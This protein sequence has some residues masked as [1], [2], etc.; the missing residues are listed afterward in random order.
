MRRK[1]VIVGGVAGGA[2]AAARLRRLDETAEIVMVEKGEHISFANCGLPYYIGNV[3]EEREALLLQTV[4]GMSTRFN[5]DI[6]NL[7]E[8]IGINREERTVRI[9]NLRTNEEYNE[10]YD[11]LVLSPGAK[12]IRPN[13]PGIDQAENIFTLRNIPDTDAIK[14]YIETC[15]T[16][17]A[18]VIGGG[19]IGVEMAENLWELGIDVSL[20]EMSNQVMSPIDYEMAAILH[21][22]MRNKG[23][24]LYLEDGVKSFEDHGTNVVLSSGK[25]IETNLIILAIGVTPENELA[26]QAGLELG[27]K[28]TI[29][30]NDQL[31]TS[32]ENIYALGD[33]ICVKDYIN[34]MPAMIPLAWPANRQGRLVADHISGKQVTYKGTL[35]TSIAQVFDLTVAATGNNEKTLKRAEIDY[36]VIHLHPNAHAGYYPNATPISLKL[37][38]NREGKILG[39]QGIGIQGVDKRIDVIATAI[40]GNLTVFD[41]PDLELS[42][43][44]PYS[45]AKDP[46]NMAGY[47]ASNLL[48]G[49]F[50]SIQ[51]HE[52]GEVV[53]SGGV[54]IDVREPAEVIKGTI[55]TSV[56]IPLN[57][58]RKKLNELSKDVPLY[59]FCQVGLRGYL[60]TRILTAHGYT[61][62]NIDGGYQ[63]YKF[64]KLDEECRV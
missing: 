22:H 4:E 52:V 51:W 17:K 18:V 34:G 5:M 9:K 30:V 50:E 14:A 62:K 21:E 57:Q 10:T 25:T 60:A 44:P 3:I 39:A 53:A 32:D 45:S 55:S 41:L 42:Y 61:V 31:Q 48:G 33:A 35:G 23:I 54:L 20:I 58:L 49:E 38:F 12:P 36:K 1:V 46:V 40:K 11:V 29:A 2:T 43:A 19:F 7:S 15:G 56:N 63:T 47:M 59:V 13:I 26:K 8:V 6:R 37:I 27:I 64:T 28:D 16:K 24:H